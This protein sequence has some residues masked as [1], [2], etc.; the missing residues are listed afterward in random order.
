MSRAVNL[1]Q[2]LAGLAMAIL[3]C[4]GAVPGSLADSAA[5]VGQLIAEAE[6]K[7][8]QAREQGHGWSST[9]D[10]LSSAKAELSAGD[11]ARALAIAERALL[12]ANASLEQ[13]A[14]EQQAWRARVPA[15]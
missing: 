13:A 3:L 10:L 1:R 14:D 15:K 11:V 9:V 8:A 6:E 4:V 7:H 5:E 2:A 12:T